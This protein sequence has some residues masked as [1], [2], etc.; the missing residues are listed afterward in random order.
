MFISPSL[1]SSS[2]Q[3]HR[4]IGLSLPRCS[5]R[6]RR[7][8]SHQLRMHLTLGQDDNP[9]P[10]PVTPHLSKRQP[11]IRFLIPHQ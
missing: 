7:L 10:S 1:N 5:F 11:A 2:K 6:Y 3:N 4:Y 8:F 9:P